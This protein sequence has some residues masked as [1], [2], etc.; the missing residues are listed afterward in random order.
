M[1]SSKSLGQIKFAEHLQYLLTLKGITPY[2]L[3]QMMGRSKNWA[4]EL[5]KGRFKP[6]YEDLAEMSAIL[7][8][9]GLQHEAFMEAGY[10]AMTPDWIAERYLKL[11][12][13]NK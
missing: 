8:L 13:K 6:N 5:I 1:G 4:N 10:L 12:E 9:K 7:G 2:A 11:K 3:N